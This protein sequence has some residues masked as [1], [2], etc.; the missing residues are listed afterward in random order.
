VVHTHL[1]ETKAERDNFCALGLGSTASAL[2]D[3]GFFDARV[4]AAHSVWVDPGDLDIY[5]RNGVGVAHCPGSNA[6]L[7]AGIAPAAAMLAA[8]VQVGLGTDGA[9]TNNDH[10]LWHELLL[11][12]LLAKAVA[13]DPTPLSAG[14]AL[15]MATRMGARAIHLPDIGVLAPGMKADVIALKSDDAAFTPVF[16]PETYL[17]HLVYSGGSRLV[18]SVWVNGKLAVRRGELLTVEETR[19]R[20]AAQEAALAVFSRVAA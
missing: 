1:V 10:D 16:T 14:Q 5:A 4:I 18:D 3:I 12:P 7:G 19:A 15:W 13:L 11:A 6:K 8:G 20:M 2:E 9:A 17:G